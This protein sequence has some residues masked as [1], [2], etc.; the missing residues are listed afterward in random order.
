M[1]LLT[2]T[3]LSIGYGA[4][5]LLTEANFRLLKGEH[6]GLVGPNGEGKS[7]FLN[8]IT[9][10]ISPDA[11][12][13][14]WHKHARVGYLDQH[15]SLQKGM[16]I[17]KV[18]RESFDYLYALEQKMY[19]LYEE[20]A[21][22]D[23]D[24]AGD[25]I[26]DAGEIGEQLE[27]SGFYIIDA[28]IDQ[29]ASG[30]GLMDIGMD[31]DVSK[32][33]GG[34]R[35]KVLLAKLLLQNPSILVLD[36][37]TNFLDE[38]HIQWL[39]NYLIQ[40]ENAFI[41]VSHDV[42]FLNACVNVIYHVE[43][44]ELTRYTGDYYKFMEMLALKKEQQSAA[45]VKQQ[46]QIA[47]LEEFIAKNKARAATSNMAMSRQKKLDK[48]ELISRVQE[49]VKPNFLFKTARTPG[50]IIFETKNLVIGYK[51]ALNNPIHLVLERNK[52]I[53]IK[54]VNGIGKTTLLKT[55][56]GQLSPFSGSVWKD[57]FLEI[58]YFAQEE[59]SPNKTA[60]EEIQDSF[61]GMTNQEVRGALAACGLTRNH[62]ESKIQVLSGGEQAK[63][64][65]C[66]ITLQT[67]N[68][69]VLD[70]PTN[71]LD[72]DAKEALK[73][74]L[75][76]YKGTIILVSHDPHFY[77]DIVEEVWDAEKWSKLIV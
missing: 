68:V 12:R 38:D 20:S 15:V 33:S 22:C 46:K 72:V 45:Y 37:P 76:N 63:V 48:M 27:Q 40:Y 69:L 66:K 61:P 71:H 77:Q 73:T 42:E 21:A 23:P 35:S 7:T 30:L 29:V 75:Q 34:Q 44:A 28:K 24:L 67:S 41:L 43:N 13:I 17:R 64:R 18:C 9:G 51:E 16:S 2:V 26:E 53:A 59:I 5:T 4:R 31:T 3:N 6:V 57:P 32:L 60:L 11:G 50:R 56:T 58:G 8:I 19:A 54:G 55:L 65:L 70:E 62:I 47:G 52:K 74:A 25:L 14:E 10:H 36:E 39:K 49:K 1:S